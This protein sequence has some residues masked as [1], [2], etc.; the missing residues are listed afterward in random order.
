MTK[1]EIIDWIGKLKPIDIP[2]SEFNAQGYLVEVHIYKKDEKLYK[3]KFFDDT[4]T[5]SEGC[6]GFKDGFYLPEEVTKQTKMIEE[7]T[8]IPKV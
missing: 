6:R 1:Q 4:P 3:I 5:D 2:Y 8:Y 7:V